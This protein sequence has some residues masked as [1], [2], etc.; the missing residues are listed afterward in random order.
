MF[1]CSDQHST[2]VKDIFC[3]ENMFKVAF[4]TLVMTILKYKY[5]IITFYVL[6]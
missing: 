2:A 1:V 3:L 5:N 4:H 6:Q